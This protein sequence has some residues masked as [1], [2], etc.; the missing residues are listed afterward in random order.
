MYMCSAPSV[1]GVGLNE[2]VG[3]PTDLDRLLRLEDV[4]KAISLSRSSIY[5]LM[6]DGRFPRPVR[7][8]RRN[9]AVAWRHSD[10]SKY[11]SELETSA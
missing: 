6:R 7:I 5:E 2:S 4:V 1:V 8:G 9:G 11:L 10:I 3:Q